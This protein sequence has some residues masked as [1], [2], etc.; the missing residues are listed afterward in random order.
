ML[1]SFALG[2]LS[3]TGPKFAALFLLVTILDPGRIHKRII[4]VV[5]VIYGLAVIGMEVI[6]FGAVQPCGCAVG[7]R[8]GEVLA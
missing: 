3:F 6:N 7:R 1:I 5:S 8:R 4:W 2:I